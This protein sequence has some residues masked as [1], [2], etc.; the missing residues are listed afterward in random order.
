MP[1]GGFY[2]GA[3]ERRR[4]RRKEEEGYRR[5]WKLQRDKS[6]HICV[7]SYSQT[8]I[9][10]SLFVKFCEGTLH[11]FFGL[12]SWPRLLSLFRD[13]RGHVQGQVGRVF[14]KCQLLI[15]RLRK[16]SERL[17]VGLNKTL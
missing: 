10:Q 5:C 1:E 7:C 8:A 16:K 11:H 12:I 6:H 2:V 17:G 15:I 14:S 4:R 13:T 3:A 9:G